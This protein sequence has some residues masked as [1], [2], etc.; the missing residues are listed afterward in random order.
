MGFPKIGVILGFEENAIN[1][2]K[3][4]IF[5]FKFKAQTWRLNMK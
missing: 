4:L 5:L 3:E 1:F 2:G